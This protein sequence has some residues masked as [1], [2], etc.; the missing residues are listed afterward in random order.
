MPGDQL[1]L[2]ALGFQRRFS[3]MVRVAI[4]RVRHVRR[5]GVLAQCLA[6]RD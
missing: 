1:E 2:A 4:A 5:H 3:G 6:S